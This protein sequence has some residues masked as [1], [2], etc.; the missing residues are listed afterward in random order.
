M[1]CIEGYNVGLRP[2]GMLRSSGFFTPL[3]GN[4]KP[5]G[6]NTRISMRIPVQSIYDAAIKRRALRKLLPLLRQGKRSC[7]AKVLTPFYGLNTG[8]V[9]LEN[10]PL[11]IEQL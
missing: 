7:S 8:S 2:P 5:T 9:R 6:T 4:G 10:D 3:T 1:L 11:P